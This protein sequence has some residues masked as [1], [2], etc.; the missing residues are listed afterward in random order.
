MGARD[1]IRGVA[2]LFRR[3]TPSFLPLELDILAEV[4]TLLDPVAADKLRRQISHVNLV[5]RLD[6]GRETNA[7]R[8]KSGKPV[9]DEGLA[10]TATTVEEM[11]LATF[12]FTSSSGEFYSGSVWV[13]RGQLF[14]LEFDKPTEHVLD[15]KPS[16]LSVSLAG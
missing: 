16:R 4:K 1:L 12:S 14:T 10:L 7:Y 2:G 15:Q 6:G 9:L 13:V 11:Q 5:Q 8:L 3:G